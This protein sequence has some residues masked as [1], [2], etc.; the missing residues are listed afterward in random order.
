MSATGFRSIV[1]SHYSRYPHSQIED[2]YKLTYQAALGS[3][4]AV[5]DIKSARQWLAQEMAQLSTCSAEPIIDEIS[6]DKGIVRVHLKPYINQGFDPEHLLQAFIR[7]ANEYQGSIGLLRRYWKRIEEMAQE[8]EIVFSPD[9]LRSFIER[10]K[11]LSFPAVH[12]SAQYQAAYHPSYR[13]I[14]RDFLPGETL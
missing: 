5:K 14:I 8:G 11:T 9:S 12:H 10:M 13:V 1:L 4:H 3:E 7:T 2:L 6:P